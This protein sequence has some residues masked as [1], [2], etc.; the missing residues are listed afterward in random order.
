MGSLA[1]ALMLAALVGCGD[2]DQPATRGGSGWTPRAEISMS[3]DGD[4]APGE[5]R[6]HAEA[7]IRHQR[8]DHCRQRL[9]RVRCTERATDWDCRWETNKRDGRTRLEKDPDGGIPVSCPGPPLD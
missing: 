2:D 1:L 3:L 5:N 8:E 6:Q 9:M 7:I 4:V